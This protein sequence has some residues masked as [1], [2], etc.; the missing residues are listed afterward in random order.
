MKWRRSR[1]AWMRKS[2]S[3]TRQMKR[4][5][6][7]KGMERGGGRRGGGAGITDDGRQRGGEGGGSE[8]R[9]GRGGEGKKWIVEGG[10]GVKKEKED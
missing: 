1:K 9:K 2:K 8:G 4:R 7:K 10:G 3:F 6:W 5:S